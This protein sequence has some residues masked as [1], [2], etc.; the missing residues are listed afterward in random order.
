[1]YTWF[2]MDN[3][4]AEKVRTYSAQVRMELGINGHVL[5]I[6]QLGPDF[7]LLRE[8]AD[9]PPSIAEI[10][11]WIDSSERRWNVYLPDGINPGQTEIRIAP[12]G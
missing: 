8:P 10:A 11:L 9:F 12:C 5:S 4:N 6:G 7:L 1:M 3:D 2:L